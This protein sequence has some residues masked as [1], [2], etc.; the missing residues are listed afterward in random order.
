MLDVVM[1]GDIMLDNDDN[2]YYDSVF[3][4]ACSPHAV[5]SCNVNT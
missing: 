3:Y 1:I 2:D 4:T 5:C